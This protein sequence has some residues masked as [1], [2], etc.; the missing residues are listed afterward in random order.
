VSS[1]LC[2]I[3]IL[4]AHILGKCCVVVNVS[5]SFFGLRIKRE[6]KLHQSSCC[7]LKQKAALNVQY[8]LLPGTD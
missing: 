6:F 3:P 4:V 7:L 2:G 5:N 1:D 8:R